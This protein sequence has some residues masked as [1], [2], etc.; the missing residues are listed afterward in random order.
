[1]G[2]YADQRI[3][4]ILRELPK[5]SAGRKPKEV[6]EP[7]QFT[8]REAIESANIDHHTAIDLQAMAAN[9]DVVEAVIAKAEEEGRIVSR[10]QVLK[11]MNQHDMSLVDTP[12]KREAE[13]ESRETKK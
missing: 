6:D 4:E 10:A 11:A 2:I 8:K 1:M 12:T 13:H 5:A 9:P 7:T 3:G